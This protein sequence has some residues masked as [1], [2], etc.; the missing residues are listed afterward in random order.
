MN[1]H[2][3]H[4]FIPSRKCLKFLL[5]ISW[6]PDKENTEVN[7][8]FYILHYSYV[9]LSSFRSHKWAKA[10]FRA[11]KFEFFNSSRQAEIR[12]RVAKLRPGKLLLEGSE[13]LLVGG[14][15][16]NEQF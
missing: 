14:K 16:N 13:I 1:R 8:F 10:C 4:S 2:S 12:P 5:S 7:S 11:F 15:K 9:R 6:L 3:L